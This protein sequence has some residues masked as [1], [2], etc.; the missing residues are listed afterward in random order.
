MLN[1]TFYGSLM[2]GLKYGVIKYEIKPH[3]TKI[4]RGRDRIV[5]VGKG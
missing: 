5:N 3:G 2:A 4:M 1:V